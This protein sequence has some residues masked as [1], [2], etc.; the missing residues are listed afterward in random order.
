MKRTLLFLTILSIGGCST[1]EE[2]NTCESCAGT[3]ISYEL[4]DNGNGIYTLS[5]GEASQILTQADLIGLS[6]KEYVNILCAE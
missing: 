4:C 3:N 1:D 6:V 5:K 2:K